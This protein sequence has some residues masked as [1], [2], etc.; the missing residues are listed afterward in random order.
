MIGAVTAG[1]DRS[2]RHRGV[3]LF[4]VPAIEQVNYQRRTG[5]AGTSADDGEH[6]VRPFDPHAR[7]YQRI[8]PRL[9]GPHHQ[10]VLGPDLFDQL[11][12]AAVQGEILR[13]DHGLE[14]I[15]T[16]CIQS[17][18]EPVVARHDHR[19]R[20][21]PLGQGGADRL[22]VPAPLASHGIVVGPRARC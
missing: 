4:V 22:D 19:K 11:A 13:H 10:P 9:A 12:L 17:V 2:Q 14:T 15:Q 7:G 3:L 16:A 8:Q 20:C 21:V 18:V 1:L 6:L 5:I